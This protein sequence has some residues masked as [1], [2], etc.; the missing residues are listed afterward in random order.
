MNPNSSRKQYHIREG[1]KERESLYV[2][3]A[4]LLMACTQTAMNCLEWWLKKWGCWIVKEQEQQWRSAVVL[5]FLEIDDTS[6]RQAEC[7]N[8][9]QRYDAIVSNSHIED[10]LT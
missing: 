3:S 9:P 8:T 7:V 5:G 1:H 4:L 10:M 2:A 6:C